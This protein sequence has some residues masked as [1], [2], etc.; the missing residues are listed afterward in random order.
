MLRFVTRK[1]EESQKEIG[2]VWLRTTYHP[3]HDIRRVLVVEK[4]E[5]LMRPQRQS[6]SDPLKCPQGSHTHTHTQLIVFNA[7]KL[8]ATLINMLPY[9]VLA[10][11]ISDSS[12]MLV[13]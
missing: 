12:N 4:L 8:L 13:F 7:N 5:C 10:H 1:N 6:K 9:L 11:Q 3:Q 2:V